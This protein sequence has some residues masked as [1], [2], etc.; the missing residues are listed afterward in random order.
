VVDITIS[1]IETIHRFPLKLFA[2]LS[3]ATPKLLPGCQHILLLEEV[4]LENPD[5]KSWAK[6]NSQVRFELTFIQASKNKST[7]TR[8]TSKNRQLES[9]L[10]QEV[11]SGQYG[12]G[13]GEGRRTGES[14]LQL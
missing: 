10:L 4:F 7:Q 12:F 14:N 3:R 9:G 8:K 1:L 5:N 6:S 13:D 11:S 2:F